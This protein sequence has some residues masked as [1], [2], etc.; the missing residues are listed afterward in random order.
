MTSTL[1]AGRYSTPARHPRSRRTN[2]AIMLAL[3]L[4]VGLVV[5]VVAYRN[6]GPTPISGDSTGFSVDNDAAVTVQFSVTRDD[7][8]RAAVCILRALS[9]DASETGRREMYIPPTSSTISFYR[10]TVR[11]SRPPVTGNVFGC[12]YTVPDYL[13]PR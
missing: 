9:L 10:T 1:P 5:T 11:T 2:V 4:I 8:S 12:S 6:L 3:G 13:Q 7:P